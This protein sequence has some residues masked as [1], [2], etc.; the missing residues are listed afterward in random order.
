MLQIMPLE[1]E[2]KTPRSYV[3]FTGILNRAFVV[4]IT[5]YLGMGVFGYLRYGNNIKESITLNLLNLDAT[6]VSSVDR[7]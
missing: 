3:G 2:M 1:N 6:D 7:M 4:I 5:L